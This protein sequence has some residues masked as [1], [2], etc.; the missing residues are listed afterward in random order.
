MSEHDDHFAVE[1]ESDFAQ[2]IREHL[3][4]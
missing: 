1:A 3:E 4:L 2:A